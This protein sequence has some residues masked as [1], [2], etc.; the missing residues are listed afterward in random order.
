MDTNRLLEE[1]LQ[2]LNELKEVETDQFFYTRLKTKMEAKNVQPSW[3]LP[4]K[5]IWVLGTLIV[6]VAL[7]SLV[8]TQD[9]NEQRSVKAGTIQDFAS[10]YGQTIAAPY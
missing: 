3:S 6:F 10:V 5:P 7:N 1:H 9:W 8:L 4:L 2:I